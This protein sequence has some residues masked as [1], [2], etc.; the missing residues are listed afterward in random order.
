MMAVKTATCQMWRPMAVGGAIGRADRKT[1]R[2]REEGR[3]RTWHVMFHDWSGA[4][5]GTRLKLVA[6]PSAVAAMRSVAGGG[7]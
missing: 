4:A 6:K 3:V 5:H 1:D 2:C 7:K